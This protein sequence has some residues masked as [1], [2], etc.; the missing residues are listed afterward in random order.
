MKVAVL[1]T[2]LM[3]RPIAERLHIAGHEVVAY[4]RTTSKCESLRAQG[5]AV[6]PTPAAALAGTDC[7]ILI[8]S[9]ALAIRSVLFS[10]S[11]RPNLR[12]RTI[13]QMG[14]ISP[15]ESRALDADVRRQGGAYLEAPVLGSITEVRHGSLLVMVGGTAEQFAKWQSLLTCLCV[16]PRLIGPVGQAAALKLA[17]NQLIAAHIASF[18]LALGYVQRMGVP[19]E[20]FRAVLAES[21][22]SA[23][24][25]EKKFPRL[26]Q[27]QYDRP[28]F[29]VKHLLK[30][31][32]LFLDEAR[33][34]GLSAESLGGVSG[35]LER[36][37]A[38][39]LGD[40][41]YAAIFETIYPRSE[42]RNPRAPR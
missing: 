1:G 27:R 39:G 42:Q 16:N 13:L 9:D 22:L 34:T 18:S 12:A 32:Q 35:L 36:T 31:V 33:R 21:A 20:L 28:N 10:D 5:I 19:V 15:E 37:I 40:E 7:A 29:P 26:D 4:N 14:T 38:R 8:L 30:D 17:L 11:S 41:D 24:M 3:G 6:A 25:F 2:G 23:P